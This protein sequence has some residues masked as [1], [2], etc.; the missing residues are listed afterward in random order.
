MEFSAGGIV[1]RETK[2]GQEIAFIED[3]WH[4]W[5]FAKGHIEKGEKPADAALR[6]ISEEMG[7]PKQH[8]KI[9]APLGRSSWWFYERRE[10]AKSPKGSL[11]HKFTYYFLIKTRP[12]VRFYPQKKELIHS[13]RWFSLD[14]ALKTLSYKNTAH[15]LRKAIK[16]LQL[17]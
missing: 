6:E 15:V 16:F 17:K 3:P 7:V 8:L 14:D 9:I 11:V 12:D 2:R 1:F 5:T 13:V 10:G 4:R